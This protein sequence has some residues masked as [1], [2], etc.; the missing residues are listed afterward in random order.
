MALPDFDLAGRT[1]LVVG[2]SR[3]IGK[4]IAAVLAE[5]GADVAIASLNEQNS[6]RMAREIESLGRRSMAVGADATKLA[7]MERLA[8]RVIG[9]W[10]NLDVLVN[11][12]GDSI[13][14]HVAPLPGQ[15]V[16]VMSEQDWHA[17]LDVNL[18]EAFTGCRAFGAH[19]LN[20]G[21]GS[22]I[23]ISSF[24]AILPRAEAI[25]YSAGKAG[26]TRFTDALALDWGPYG[27]RVNAIAPG[28]FPDPDQVSPDFKRQQEERALREVPL[29]RVGLLREV[30]LMAVYLASDAAS[31]VTGQTFYIDGGLTIA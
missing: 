21:T 20:R 25:A 4:G 23:N 17:I 7:D 3:G 14:A 13:R 11:A 19:F 16:R 5:A 10:G 18:T 31:Y 28:Y 22:V 9:E 12:V 8:E 29:R 6:R 30:G 2:G 26:L 24:A 27:V 1:A 15:D